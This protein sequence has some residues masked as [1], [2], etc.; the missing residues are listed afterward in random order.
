MFTRKF[1]IGLALSIVLT[2]CSFSSNGKADIK[3]FAEN[4]TLRL[5]EQKNIATL[6]SV[7]AS[8]STSM[9][10][11][12]NVQEGLM[13]M[14]KDKKL[15]NG[16]AEDVETN[17]DKTNYTFKLRKDAKW[18]DGTPITAHDF[19]YAWKRAINPKEPTDYGYIFAPI[20]NAENYSNGKVSVDKVGIMA[21]NDHTLQVKLVKPQNNFLSLTTLPAFLPQKKDLV[22]KA[23]TKYGTVEGLQNMVYS[24]PFK[25]DSW[26]NNKV[27]LSKNEEYW[28]RP[29]VKLEKV[30]LYIGMD[31][32]TGINLYNTDRIDA[33]A[34]DQAYVEVYK[35]TP[36]FISV[37]LAS[38]NYI[39]LRI[40]H[41]EGEAFF[42]NTNIRK[43]INLAIDRDVLA[44][45]IMKDGSKPAGGFVPPSLNGVGNESFRKHGE[46]V[47]YD[48]SKAKEYWKKGLEELKL[49]SAPEEI[50]MISYNSTAKR[51]MAVAIKEQL[52]RNLG[53]NVLLDAPPWSVHL[54]NLR[55][56]NYQMGMLGWGADYND[57]ISFLEIFQSDAGMNWAGFSNA[58]YDKLLEQAKSESN[59]AKQYELLKQAEQI[60]VG[61]EG[62]GQSAIIPLIY[63][64]NAYI[65]KPHVKELY[66]HAYGPEYSLKWAYLVNE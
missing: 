52:R 66:R 38:S 15:V 18:S 63:A 32:P 27:V 20:V 54:Q 25:V 40:N 39:L 3:G 6:D 34:L 2:G 55:E 22:E 12:N 49:S 4:Q 42:K 43:A 35:Q 30:E 31:I 47:K 11:L 33:T 5:T 48:V 51:D 14:G 28:D 41:K 53:L 57:P 65:Q 45:K 50:Q 29:A 58:E 24:G 8:D 60:L 1:C 56:G 23:K 9:N 36:D 44:N 17:K 46:V 59:Q 21:P 37:E 26:A 7:K 16:I 64:S 62:K 13:R 61:T 10:V 19:A